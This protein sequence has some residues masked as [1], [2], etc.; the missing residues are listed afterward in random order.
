MTIS[1]AVSAGNATRAAPGQQRRIPAEMDKQ[2]GYPTIRSNPTATRLKEPD[3]GQQPAFMTS[4][5]T[6]ASVLGGGAYP[7]RGS[8]AVRMTRYISLYGKSFNATQGS[9]N[10]GYTVFCIDAPEKGSRV[11]CDCSMF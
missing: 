8:L 6:A 3:G 11:A 4:T 2:Y 5:A 7:A 10:H 1:S 9:R